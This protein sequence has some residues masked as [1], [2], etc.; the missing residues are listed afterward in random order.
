MRIAVMSDIHGNLEALQA[1]LQDIK[2]KNVDTIVCLG[3]LVGYGPFPNEVIDRV[4]EENI[5]VIIGN[6]DT[7]VVNNDIKYIKDNELNK[8]FALPW[9]VNKV[10]E[11]NKKYLK[12][13]PDDMI[14][15]DKG[16]IIKFVH[17]STRKV[18]EYLLENSKE[19]QEVMEEYNG[20]ILVCAH[21][22]IPYV[23]QYEKKIL[24]N[25]GSVGK[26]KIGRPNASYSILDFDENNFN[27]ENLEVEYDYEKTVNVMK[28]EGFPIKLI[29]SIENG[30]A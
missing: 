10:S 30:R 29:E 20:D 11:K 1:V 13:L 23:K 3:D 2:S 27:V 6:Y 28:K 4:R 24:V 8:N 19:A 21:T 14:I 7:A 26:P 16:K 18:N 25:D 9:S 5:L 12:R 22:H 15:S 17:G